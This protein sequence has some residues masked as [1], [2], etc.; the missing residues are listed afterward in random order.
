MI[1]DCKKQMVLCYHANQPSNQYSILS[2][3]LTGSFPGISISS[4]TL[5]AFPH[6]Y[7]NS[8]KRESTVLKCLFILVYSVT[9]SQAL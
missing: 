7:E 3:V 1:H 2:Q 8:C 6:I 4:Q 5:D 9:S